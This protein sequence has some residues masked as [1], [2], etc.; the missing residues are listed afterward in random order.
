MRSVG[1]HNTSEWDKEGKKERNRVTVSQLSL[2]TI[3]Q[4][5]MNSEQRSLCCPEL[6]RMISFSGTKISVTPNGASGLALG[7][8]IQYVLVLNKNVNYPISPHISRNYVTYFFFISYFL[9]YA[10]S[11]YV[12]YHLCRIYRLW[13]EN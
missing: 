11:C 10:L 2:V 8:H 12:Y 7:D 5:Q 1:A 13:V 3:T 4:F 9:S 6:M